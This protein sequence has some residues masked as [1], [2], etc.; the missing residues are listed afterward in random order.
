MTSFAAHVNGYRGNHSVVLKVLELLKQMHGHMFTQHKGD[1]HHNAC[2]HTCVHMFC[3]WQ[4]RHHKLSLKHSLT[5]HRYSELLFLPHLLTRR[6]LP[7]LQ[8]NLIGNVMILLLPEY[9]K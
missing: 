6:K 2:I 8:W 1:K 3:L 7:I 9:Q 5:K 4:I